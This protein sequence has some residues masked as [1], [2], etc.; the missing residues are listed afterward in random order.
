M[1]FRK[2]SLYIICCIA[3]LPVNEC[4]GQPNESL[5]SLLE[6]FS[7]FENRYDLEFSYNPSTVENIRVQPIQNW[8]I[9]W[10]NNLTT[11]LNKTNLEWKLIQSKYVAILKKDPPKIFRKNIRDAHSGESLPYA[12]LQFIQSGKGYEADQHGRFSFSYSKEDG[13]SIIVRYLGYRPL[14]IV[15]SEL[16]SEIDLYQ[17]EYQLENVVVEERSPLAMDFNQNEGHYGLNARQIQLQAGWGDPDVLRMSQLLPGIQTSDESATNINVRGGTPD[18]NLILWDDIPVYHIGHFFGMFSAFNPYTIDQIE[19]YKGGFDATKGG[20]VSSIVDLKSMIAPYQKARIGLGINLINAYAYA[21]I[22]ILKNQ[23]SANISIR[24]SLSENLQTGTYQ[25]VFNRLFQT[26]KISEYNDIEEQDLLNRNESQ[27]SFQEFSASVKWH[28]ANPEDGLKLSIFNNQDRFSHAFEVDQPWITHITNDEFTNANQGINLHLQKTFFKKWVTGLSLLHSD[29]KYTF[30]S[31]YSANIEDDYHAK[32]YIENQLQN[33]S[34][35]WFNSFSIHPE[36]TLDFGY[37]TNIWDLRLLI[38]YQTLWDN[39]EQIDFSIGNLV[40]T[41][42]FNYVFKKPS[43]LQMN[44]GVRYNGV[45]NHGI[46]FWEPRFS[47][48]YLLPE[49]NWSLK[50]ATGKYVQYV[51]QVLLPNDLSVGERIW[52]TAGIDDI[53]IV[54]LTDLILGLQFMNK[55]SLVSIEAYYKGTTGLSKLNFDHSLTDND[56]SSGSSQAAGIEFFLQRKW[57]AYRMFLSY[58]YARVLYT[59]QD[60]IGNDNFPAPHDQPHVFRFGQMYSFKDWEFIL[61]THINS[62]NPFSIGDHIQEQLNPETDE[63][64]YEV[65]YSRE[66]NGRFDPYYRLDLS[67]QKR[68]LLGTTSIV[69]GG[70][71]FNLLNTNNTIDRHYYIWFPDDKNIPEISFYN[72]IGMKRTFNFYVR[73]EF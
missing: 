3:C 42:Y 10:K 23:I 52:A 65:Q 56:F 27:F 60:F 8:S 71:W 45:A 13:D 34:F 54:E 31:S 18:Q 63:A 4:S 33:V 20:R 53:P 43:V 64:Y 17:K 49:S 48:N 2:Y 68:W 44:L 39:N 41:T 15:L 12:T 69:I 5:I 16:G 40:H 28:W 66:N 11:L 36:H 50:L 22:P 29:Y 21:K 19:I 61:N 25:K 59:F 73:C 62:G 72:E 46:H 30:K 58:N 9:P 47:F 14:N 6:I 38:D 35:K 55:R 32:G 7:E 57:E 70:S 1:I 37:R 26:G 67:I 51:S 24:N